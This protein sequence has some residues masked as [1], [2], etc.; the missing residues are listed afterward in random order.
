MAFI[1]N[2]KSF[3]SYSKEIKASLI[4]YFYVTALVVLPVF[5]D[6]FSHLFLDERITLGRLINIIICVVLLYFYFLLSV[7]SK[8]LNLGKSHAYKVKLKD[9]AKSIRLPLHHIQTKQK[10]LVSQIDSNHLKEQYTDIKSN[11]AVNSTLYA[12]DTYAYENTSALDP[13]YNSN[14]NFNCNPSASDSHTTTFNTNPFDNYHFDKEASFDS[15]SITD[16]QNSNYQSTYSLIDELERN[17]DKYLAKNTSTYTSSPTTIA[18]ET[19]TTE[20]A[21]TAE[22]FA[23]SAPSSSTVT[24]AVGSSSSSSTTPKL[25]SAAKK[26]LSTVTNGTTATT[27]TTSTTAT[28]SVTATSKTK[29][30]THSTRNLFKEDI[31]TK[32]SIFSPS[33]FKAKATTNYYLHKDF[34][35]EITYTYLGKGFEFKPDHTRLLNN[36][37]N[38]GLIFNCD[39][40]HGSLQIHEL[41]KRNDKSLFTLTSNLKGHTIIF[42]TTG[43]GKTRAFDLFI[44]QAIL[45]NEVVIVID[46]KGDR[47]LKA[48]LYKVA[49]LIGREDAVEVL[50]LVNLKNTTSPFNLLGSSNK[51]TQIADRLTSLMSNNKDNDFANYAHQAVAAAVIA[52]CFKHKELNL[53]NITN[54][55]NLISLFDGVLNFII[56]FL[57]KT[58]NDKLIEVFYCFVKDFKLNFKEFTFGDLLKDKILQLE[59]EKQLE[60]EFAKVKELRGSSQN[61]AYDKSSDDTSLVSEKT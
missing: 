7:D 24:V 12:T 30:N 33:L 59:K 23:T 47:D 5:Y 38:T 4:R 58:N 9:L 11:T 43:S 45:R 41:E 8:I 42:G 61:K 21:T 15:L 10:R 32:T 49:E 35:P 13:T 22:A 60:A 34:T 25:S 37:L 2:S 3:S 52:L 57:V 48:N 28:T 29:G 36:L 14:S 17:C 55:L 39:E 56:T 51:P 27:G 6:L 19:E 44:S 50:D 20:A 54:N 31:A 26:F 18:L 46:P 1:P 53:R 16:L 40:C